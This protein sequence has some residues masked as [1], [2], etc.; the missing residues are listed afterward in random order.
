MHRIAPRAVWDCSLTWKDEIAPVHQVIVA[1]PASVK[2][3][4]VDTR[5]QVLNILIICCRYVPSKLTSST[6]DWLSLL[7]KW[8]CWKRNWVAD[9][10]INQTVCWRLCREPFF[11]GVV[12]S[13]QLCRVSV[14]CC[15]IWGYLQ[16][17]YID[18]HRKRTC[19]V[20][21][22]FP[23][24]VYINLNRHDSQI[25]VSFVCGCQHVDN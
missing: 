14:K 24:K 21:Q 5:E 18:W 13:V 3:R 7:L 25:W 10:R 1:P 6:D 20:Y 17:A 15:H 2:D 9:L 8:L 11:S 19:R 4:W 23:C 22:I 12:G 16:K